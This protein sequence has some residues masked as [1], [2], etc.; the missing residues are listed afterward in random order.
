MLASRQSNLI[1]VRRDA[2]I[3]VDL[4]AIESNI[5]V[6]RSWLSPACKLLAVV[7]SDA[8]GLGASQIAR[9]LTGSGV[10]WFGVASVDEGCQLRATGVV[11]PILIL[12]PCP[13][14]AM[15]TAIA[16]DL[17]V[18]VTSLSQAADLS[19]A[20][21]RI[22]KAAY[23][24]VKV[25]TG[26]HRI[27]L[28]PATA[29]DL[30]SEIAKQRSLRLSGLFS[31]LACA[32]D[33]EVTSQQDS[34]FSQVITQLE[35]AGLRPG[36]THLASGEAARRFP[37]THH[38]MVR[39]GLYLYGLEPRTISQVVTPAMSVRG[40]INHLEEISSGASVGYG[41]T[42]TARRTSRLASI[43]IGY[44]DGVDRRLSNRL[45][46]LI[47]G[48]EVQQVGLISMDQMLFDLTNVP[49][50]AVGDVITLIGSDYSCSGAAV[51]TA[52]PPGKTLYLANWAQ[53][54]DTITYE[55]ACRLRVRLPHVYTRHRTVA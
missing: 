46:G 35:E 22:G 45:V 26:M 12:S 4:A 19:C 8:Y 32:N 5:K 41:W 52:E 29:L 20:A 34:S 39:V 25:D 24:Q 1:S 40:R 10:E 44:G 51:Q 27:G 23:V 33:A 55:L 47:M 13:A 9:V 37:A 30:I 43:P 54:L 48:K 2:W 28:A 53:A 36:L 11:Q 17:T 3:E 15:S 7:K 16:S 14:W 38:D 6:V 21:A 18:T 31:H 42:W 50:A 49:E